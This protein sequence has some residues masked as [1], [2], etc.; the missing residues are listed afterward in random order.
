MKISAHYSINLLLAALLACLG[1][2]VD[3]KGPEATLDKS[4]EVQPVKAQ[5]TESQ[6]TEQTPEQPQA[7]QAL[8]KGELNYRDTLIDLKSSYAPIS[9]GWFEQ[10]QDRQLTGYINKL[11]EDNHELL[12]AEHRVKS[13]ELEQKALKASRLPLP[14]IMLGARRQKYSQDSFQNGR[15]LKSHR[16]IFQ[17]GF[18]ATIPIDFTNKFKNKTLAVDYDLMATKLERD[19]LMVSLVSKMTETYFAL[20]KAEQQLALQ[21]ELIANQA[22]QVKIY[23]NLFDLSLANH[24]DLTR[25]RSELDEYR[26]SRNELLME[27]KKSASALLQM[28]A[29]RPDQNEAP[30]VNPL[31]ISALKFYHPVEVRSDE[32][33]NRQDVLLKYFELKKA[34]NDIDLQWK[35]AFPSFALTGNLGQR[36]FA[37]DTLFNANRFYYSLGVDL[38]EPL[39][40]IRQSKIRVQQAKQNYQG[41]VEDFK[42][43]I[44]N[45]FGEVHNLLFTVEQLDKAGLLAEEEKERRL[46]NAYEACKTDV[47]NGV[48]PK[49]DLLKAREALLKAQADKANKQFIYLQHCVALYKSLGGK[50]AASEPESP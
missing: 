25:E 44:L 6:A 41:S 37:F 36:S 11:I 31:Q 17:P 50:L 15:P 24:D 30:P 48:R 19:S 7:A 38:L 23:D 9:L 3:A 32:V 43:S 26:A 12:S 46:L 40:N 1:Q 35:S 39:A 28:L 18:N 8:L 27:R 20:S 10:F 47:A 14:E 33:L 21:E 49:L 4:M 22:E 34:K 29:S 16:S 2:S 5:P 13:A 42:S 45:A